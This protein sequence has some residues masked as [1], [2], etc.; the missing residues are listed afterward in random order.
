MLLR[1]YYYCQHAS[2][3]WMLLHANGPLSCTRTV[4]NIC[5]LDTYFYITYWQTD[6]MQFSFQRG[7]NE[8]DCVHFGQ[9]VDVVLSW[10]CFK[11]RERDLQFHFAEIL[12]LCLNPTASAVI[13]AIMYFLKNKTKK[14][15]KNTFRHVKSK[16]SL[17]RRPF[18]LAKHRG[19]NCLARA[20][21]CLRSQALAFLTSEINICGAHR[22][23]R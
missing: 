4:V 10:H 17:H 1:D 19:W 8:A 2:N 3:Y 14:E 12:G 9:Q 16:Q 6:K 13:T 23:S 15:K 7:A 11:G 20:D 22:I 18:L 5:W 21:I